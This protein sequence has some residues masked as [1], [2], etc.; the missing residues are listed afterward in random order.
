MANAN[1]GGLMVTASDRIF[2]LLTT[3][4]ELIGSLDWL[5]AEAWTRR[6][7]EAEWSAA[8]IVGHVIELEPYWARQ[9]AHLAEHPGAEVG[10]GLEDPVRLSGPD[11][12]TAL[13]AQE[14]RT[15]LAESGEQAAEI[16]RRLPDSAWSIKGSWRGT[17]MTIDE[18]IERHLIHHVREH[19]EQIT[20]ALA[21]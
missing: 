9:A 18:L 8:E 5:T 16:L 6:P 17:E 14:A 4:D 19:L 3:N 7:G 1:N 20:T 10:R 13:T 15:R 2:N 12:G 11:R 21:G